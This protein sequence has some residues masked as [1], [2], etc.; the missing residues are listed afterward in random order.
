[1]IV[2]TERHAAKPAL[3]I[4][5][6]ILPYPRVPQRR[7]LMQSLCPPTSYQLPLRHVLVSCRACILNSL[8][9]FSFNQ[10]LDSVFDHS[11]VGLEL[12]D[13]LAD[14]LGDEHG[15]L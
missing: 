11:D 7:M 15:V 13:Q 1:M 3:V 5:R 12:M 10:T 4:C 2:S 9:I 14:S 8:E 6:L